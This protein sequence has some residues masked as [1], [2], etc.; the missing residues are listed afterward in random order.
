MTAEKI[1]TYIDH[2]Q[3][4]AFCD[5]NQIQSLCDEAIKYHTASV[6]IPSCFIKRIK[7]KYGDALTICTVVGFPLG[8]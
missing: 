7:E 6:C 3:L 4:K 5:W 8:Y 1:A 2:T